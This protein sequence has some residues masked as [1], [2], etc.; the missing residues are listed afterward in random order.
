ML[1]GY[2]AIS[3]YCWSGEGVSALKVESQCQNYDTYHDEFEK[4]SG[5]CYS[6]HISHIMSRETPV[7]LASDYIRG[8]IYAMRCYSKLCI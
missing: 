5:R 3:L 4:K 8:T 2:A 6:A 7:V 1:K